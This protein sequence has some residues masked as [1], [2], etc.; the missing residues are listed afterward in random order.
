MRLIQALD[1]LADA[2]ERSHEYQE[3]TRLAQEV[4]VSPDVA[5]MLDQIRQCHSHYTQSSRSE[6]VVALESLPVML[7]YRQAERALRELCMEI[8]RLIS[9]E[10]GLTYSLTVRPQGHG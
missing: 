5:D 8:D 9:A 2:I 7:A 10:A 1:G 6:L 3:F 4:N